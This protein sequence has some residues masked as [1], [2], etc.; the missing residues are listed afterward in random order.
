M[1]PIDP[2]SGLRD[3][4][5]DVK[6]QSSIAQADS[7]RLPAATPEGDPQ[8]HGT[9]LGPYQLVSSIGRGGMG[10]VY[11]AHDTRRDRIVALKTLQR[12]DP[13]ALHRFKRE[14]RTLAGLS[15]RNLVTLYELLCEG[16]RWC[17]TME[18]VDGVTFDRYLSTAALADIRTRWDRI[19]AAFRQLAEGVQALHN[20]QKLHRD[21]KPRNA[22]VTPD[23]RVVVLDFGLA[24]EL[25]HEGTYESA[26][27]HLVGT[28]AYMSPEQAL[29]GPVAAASDWY[30]VGVM[31]FEALTGRLPFD[32]T[33]SHLLDAKVY[34][35]APVF[36]PLA[37]GAPRELIQLCMDLLQRDPRQRP[38]GLQVLERI[39]TSSVDISTPRPRSTDVPFVGREREL[40]A[41]QNA[42]RDSR[43]GHPVVVFVSGSSGAGKTALVQKFLQDVAHDPRVLVLT[44]RC[45]EQET[46][47]F[48]ALDSLVDRLTDY[49]LGLS[50]IEIQALL[51]RDAR[52]LAR[53]FPVLRKVKA[54]AAAPAVGIDDADPVELRRRAGSAL[55]E[56]L[57]RLGDRVTL[58]L[59]IDDLHWGDADSA[60]LLIDILTARDAPVFLVIG[61]HRT[62]DAAES[63][64]FQQ[65]SRT[66]PVV[67]AFDQRDVPIGAL[68]AE[69]AQELALHLLN[70]SRLPKDQM[71]QSI[72]RESAGQPF[73]VYE[74]VE[75]VKAIAEGSDPGY[76]LSLINVL[77][78]RVQGL[79]EEAR[80]LL[81]VVAIAGKPI[82]TLIACKAAGLKGDDRALM[83]LLKTTRLIRGVRNSKGEAIET[84]HDRVRQC[85][86]ARLTQEAAQEC[87][88]Q[89]ART[90]TEA[91]NPDVQALAFHFERGGDRKRASVFYAK[92]AA[93]AAQA[94]AFDQAASLYRSA[95][96]L[97][98]WP[99]DDRRRLT[100]ALADA[101]ANA[102][103]GPNAA[104]EYLSAATDAESDWSV[105]LHRRAAMQLLTSGHVDEGLR[106][107]GPVLKSAGMRLA[108]A[109]SHALLSL[110]VHRA[111]LRVRGTAFVRC[112]RD[113]AS[114]QDLSRIDIGWSAVVGLS[115]IDP[116]RA[117]DLQTRSLLLA[118]RVGEPFRVARALALEAAHRASS[119][120][121][122]SAEAVLAE[123][124]QLA[125]ALGEPYAKGIVE[126]ARGTIRYFAQRWPDSLRCFKEAEATFREQ[127]TGV[128]WEIATANAFTL[129]SLAKLGDLAE[130]GRVCPPLLKAALERGDRYAATNLSTQLM[131]LVRLGADDPDAARAD[132][133]RVMRQWSQSGY[134]IQ[135]HDALQAIVPLELYCGTP[136][137]AWQR[138]D[139]DW[140]AFR[141]SLLSHVQDVR[142]EMLQMR[143]YSALAVAAADRSRPLLQTALRGARRLRREQRP[144]A[145]G[146]ASYIEGAAAAMDGDTEAAAKHLTNAISTFDSL[147][148][149]L[150]AVATRV[151]L[152]QLI[153]GSE[154]AELTA[155]ADAWFKSQ[156]VKSPEKLTAAFSP[157][158]Q[159]R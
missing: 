17:F 31:L 96:D 82:D 56:L 117:A 12:I 29:G 79:P 140:S 105:E 19:R 156:E 95:L 102:G 30:S 49:L 130:L 139:R 66:R 98:Q 75:Q 131:T 5:H 38:P 67:S 144:S 92:A 138:V 1:E 53:V 118:L 113:T 45:Y 83:P 50:G 90:L 20:A 100:V 24:A 68:A 136:Q 70:T 71:T 146:L 2:F 94:L 135:H 157:G 61:C 106:Q 65:L 22:L 13:S 152:A 128:M 129:W 46:V 141:W 112:D 107:L 42:F 116:I 133:D 8:A 78:S 64:F 11:R 26:E 72:V 73:L 151:R 40:T 134:H 137:A 99:A 51:P 33:Q 97:Q 41:L 148:M 127:C 36:E 86:L 88:L 84:Y 63:P 115:M 60:S 126:V 15:H 119:G 35:A 153:G 28:A 109:P 124:D 93:D 7:T 14:F 89:L 4:L 81:H 21:I 103:R 32:G 104:A 85:V 159:N 27:R 62:E 154:G 55:R 25:D 54:I 80:R 39:G 91:S 155:F 114:V 120:S 69:E 37:P 77:W 34:G 74:L 76:S 150:Y 143:A 142:I 147:S 10:V 108:K 47:P 44:G 111:R 23:G 149:R 110:L 122:A 101:L 121:L 43:N 87:H 58:V 52:A 125:T 59:A 57:A 145:A 3:L 132:V 158:F 6:E 18:L 48:K 16:D 123:A 9:R